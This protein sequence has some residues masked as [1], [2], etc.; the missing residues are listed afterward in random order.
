MRNWSLAS[1]AALLVAGAVAWSQDIP[2]EMPAGAT[3]DDVPPVTPLTVF[4]N[5][6]VAWYR[7]DTG[8]V[9]VDGSFVVTQLNDRSG[10]GHHLDVA[11]T[12]QVLTAISGVPCID[13]EATGNGS[14]LGRAST[15]LT[16]E[17]FAVYAVADVESVAAARSLFSISTAGSGNNRWTLAVS[18]TPA[19]FANTF[20]TLN[21]IATHG[22]TL[23]LGTRYAIYGEFLSDTDRGVNVNGGTKVTSTTSRTVGTPTQISIGSS[24]ADASAEPYDG[25]IFEVVLLNA[26]PSAGENT[27]YLAYTTAR[28]GAP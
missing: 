4:G 20:T 16:N 22:T 25:R 6:V 18:T 8:H 7:P 17:P 26:A 23:S 14:R 10:N 15:P 11:G 13:F 3:F 28:F 1:L 19:A 5:K 12:T 9:T 21:G 27:D 24:R 2:G